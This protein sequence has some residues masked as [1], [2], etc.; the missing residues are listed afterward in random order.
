[1]ENH[2][3]NSYLSIYILNQ[4]ITKAT[5]TNFLIENCSPFTSYFSELLTQGS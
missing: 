5:A 4:G 1:M 3:M 2:S